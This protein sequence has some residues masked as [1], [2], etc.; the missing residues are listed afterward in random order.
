MAT[1]KNPS[2]SE[3][4]FELYVNRD[5]IAEDR[6]NSFILMNIKLYLHVI[7]HSYENIFQWPMIQTQRNFVNY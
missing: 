3:N 2:D 6:K 5:Q 7:D 1:T 4:K